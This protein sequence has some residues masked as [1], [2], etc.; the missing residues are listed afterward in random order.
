[1][2]KTLIICSA[3]ACAAGV[4]FFLP[5]PDPELRLIRA[6]AACVCCSLAIMLWGVFHLLDLHVHSNGRLAVNVLAFLILWGLLVMGVAVV[7]Q[8]LVP[9]SDRSVLQARWSQPSANPAVE[10][11]GAS[12]FCPGSVGSLASLAPAA[13][14]DR[15][16]DS[17]SR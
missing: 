5:L 12:P 16:A 9:A 7:L 11:T 2:K 15:W 17:D 14:R 6:V 4:G 13:H 1:M 8:R 10:R 3:F